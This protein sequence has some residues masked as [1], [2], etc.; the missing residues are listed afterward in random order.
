MLLTV[1]VT[2]AEVQ[3]LRERAVAS[4]LSLSRYLVVA[5]LHR[6]IVPAT[7]SIELAVAGQLAS[8]GS[9]LRKGLHQLETGHFDPALAELLRRLRDEI[10]ALQRQLSGLPPRAGG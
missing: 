8:L 9:D 3:V 10:E 5:G 2:A 6:K 7:S 1:R 4:R